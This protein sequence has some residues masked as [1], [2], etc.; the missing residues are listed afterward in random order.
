[1]NTKHDEV[2]TMPAVSAIEF[3]LSHEVVRGTLR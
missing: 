1:M 3:E 2:L